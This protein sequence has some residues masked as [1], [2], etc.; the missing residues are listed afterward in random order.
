MERSREKHRETY[1]SDE[2]F[3]LRLDSSDEDME[4]A[5][6][7]AEAEEKDTTLDDEETEAVAATKPDAP[8]KGEKEKSEDKDSG[9]LDTEANEEPEEKDTTLEVDEE[10]EAV[11]ETKP[12][13]PEKGEK[14]KSED[15]GG[16]YPPTHPLDTQANKETET[17]E[18]GE[19]NKGG[20]AT[21]KPETDSE[22][23]EE[24]LTQKE[25]VEENRSKLETISRNSSYSMKKKDLG[26]SFTDY[27]LMV[28]AIATSLRL[29][30]RGSSE[31]QRRFREEVLSKYKDLNNGRK[32]KQFPVD[33][34]QNIVTSAL[35][36]TN[37]PSKQMKL[38]D[39]FAKPKKTTPAVDSPIEAAET[40]VKKTFLQ[41]G[42]TKCHYFIPND[43]LDE[44][45]KKKGE[46]VKSF[47]SEAET[48][49]RNTTFTK[50]STMPEDV[51]E[52]KQRI[53]DIEWKLKE[54]E[55]I[56]K[57]AE[58]EV[59]GKSLPNQMKIIKEAS[60]K[61]DK[62]QEDL[63]KKLSAMDLAQLLKD[64]KKRNQTRLSN[65]AQS[66]KEKEKKNSSRFMN[67]HLTWKDCL[68]KIEEEHF[69]EKNGVRISEDEAETIKKEIEKNTERFI[70]PEELL[71]L[72]DR[73]ENEKKA[74]LEIC[75]KY[76]PVIELK[77]EGN[78]RLY[79]AREFLK[80]PGLMVSLFETQNQF[81]GIERKSKFVACGVIPSGP[82]T[83]GRPKGVYKLREDVVTAVQELLD[84]AG[85]P[86][87]VR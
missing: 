75:V 15:K 83:R 73:T 52:A 18:K 31:N 12:D 67:A 74:L 19:K 40:D 34:A 56:Q 4:E 50:K 46:V 24:V 48:F 43:I 1:E 20:D 84:F 36:K 41:F 37:K 13:V 28:N 17:S 86:A 82:E 11:A 66:E 33:E 23:A 7:E 9:P 8:E 70:T 81:E 16:G 71:V 77:R 51:K 21:K 85:T 3:C 65:R 38:S 78:T 63:L 79:D 10:T 29:S 58:E 26:S 6:A 30:E 2:N 35:S 55:K 80:D 87:H 60:E 68:T 25:F 39:M 57:E 44:H 59:K 42:S 53:A 61:S 14:E 49:T 62:I 5:G 64:L 76:M 69:V 32:H 45:I 22:P 72:L 47:L 27:E 54:A